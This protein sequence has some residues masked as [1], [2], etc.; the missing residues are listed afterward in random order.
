MQIATS[1]RILMTNSST[2]W[3]DD[4]NPPVK[5]SISTSS[6]PYLHNFEIIR[7]IKWSY[8]KQTIW[9]K[10]SHLSPF[11]SLFL[12]PF[13]PVELFNLLLCISFLPTLSFSFLLSLSPSLPLTL[14]H[15]FSLIL[16]LS[17]SL[18]IPL[19]PPFLLFSL[20]LTPS[21]LLS[22]SIPLCLC[23]Y[24]FYLLHYLL[25]DPQL[26]TQQTQSP[27]MEQEIFHSFI[28]RS[29]KGTYNMLRKQTWRK[30]K[31][32]NLKYNRIEK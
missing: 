17:P 31:I 16:S 27:A 14:Y 24:P 3:W 1:L 30:N 19:Y 29:S 2:L 11:L 7:H 25:P 5:I 13:L 20:S 18:P 23:L 9:N 15:A 6:L 28:M 21:I 22:V 10:F 4:E 12:S 26:Q 8:H 32:W